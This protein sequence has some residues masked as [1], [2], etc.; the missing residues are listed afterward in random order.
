MKSHSVSKFL[1]IDAGGTFTD[2]VLI[3]DNG[4][5]IHKVLSTPSNP[6]DAILQG[7]EEMGLMDDVEHGSIYIVHGST[8]A[9]NAALERKGAKT[10]Y[11]ANKGFKD[12]LTIGRQARQ[13]L[14]NLAPKVIEPPV[15]SEL[16]LE[17]D[18]R[19]GSKGEI[20]Q[21]LSD[22]DI[23]HLVNEVEKLKPEAVAINLLFSFL[24]DEEEKRLEA[25]LVDHY[26]V[27]RSSFVLPKYKEYERGIATWLNASL[28]PKVLNYM[29]RLMASLEGCQVSIMQSSGGTMAIEQAAN[30]AANLLLS[31]PAG[32][33]SAVRTIGKSCNEDRIISFDMGGTSTDVALMDGD[34]RLTDE[35]KINHWPIA[36][37]MLEM[38]T[39]GAGGGSIAWIDEAQM[40]HVGPE[41][42]GSFPGPACYGNG[43]TQ[44]TVTDANVVLGRLRPEA[45]LGG[46]MNLDYG[47]AEAAVSALA[48]QLNMDT[49]ALARGIVTIAEHQMV[50]ALHS[51]SIQKGYDPSEFL[52]CCFGGAGG[53]HVCSLAEQMK[54]D[55]AI[56][57]INSGVLSAFG[58][59]SAPKQRQYTQTYI[60][61]WSQLNAQEIERY[62]EEMEATGRHELLKEQ[63]LP[64]DIQV[65][66]SLDLRYL[67]QSFTLNIPYSDTSDKLFIQKH[68]DQYGHTLESDIEIV[69]LCVGLKAPGKVSSLPNFQPK[70]KDLSSRQVNLPTEEQK[71]SIYEREK[72]H[73]GSTLI[74]PAIITEKVSTTWL[75]PGWSLKVD[76]VGNLILEQIN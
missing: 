2:F 28:G 54:I 17:V 5:E 37:P 4:W 70:N 35:G 20:L 71:V 26:F 75:K 11:I 46:G 53:M 9:T 42:A 57:P 49:V 24:D 3:D 50:R 41:S 73:S 48:E 13:E 36:I 8:V 58:M 45:F 32:G 27:S 67:G 43:G 15:P 55:Q 66:R 69:N 33:L 62:F 10:V 40:L 59:L 72:L 6:A 38:A 7:I 61:L 1:G 30:R 51:I 76:S 39:I 14:Y 29:Q 60:R 74:G 63:T 44:P 64:E 21:A 31:G 65:E 16:C 22:E 23:E 19:R 56:V 52:L 18:C 34:F 68:L 25:A 47:K 12:V